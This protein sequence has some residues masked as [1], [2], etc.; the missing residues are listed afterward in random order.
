MLQVQWAFL[1]AC[2]GNLLK[3]GFM[4]MGAVL[5]GIGERE[6]VVPAYSC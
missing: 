2:E 3:C 4:W 5:L 1:L 6:G